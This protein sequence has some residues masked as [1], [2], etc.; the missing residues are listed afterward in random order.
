LDLE[1]CEKKEDP[2]LA[3]ER[4]RKEFGFDGNGIRR[5]DENRCKDAPKP[6]P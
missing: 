3:S 2:R 6:L 5:V 1:K 4:R